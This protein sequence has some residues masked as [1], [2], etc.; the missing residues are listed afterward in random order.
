[1]PVTARLRVIALDCSDPPAMARFYSELTGWPVAYAEADWIQLTSDCGVTLAFQ[2]APG[3]QP[4]SWPADASPLQLHLDFDV[5][6]LDAGEATVVAL[7][8][9]RCDH[10][11]TSDGHFRVFLDPAGH[12]FCLVRAGANPV[13]TSPPSS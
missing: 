9:T 7:G 2:L 10:Q 6:D 8:G 3:H 12:P 1:M 11:P 13:A 4:P 5:D